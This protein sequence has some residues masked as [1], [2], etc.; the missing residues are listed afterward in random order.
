MQYT[1]ISGPF[2]KASSLSWPA[3][4]VNQSVSS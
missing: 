3:N 1:Q 2:Q 4:F